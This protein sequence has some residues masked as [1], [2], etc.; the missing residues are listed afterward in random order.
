MGRSGPFHVGKM[1]RMI[2]TMRPKNTTTATPRAFLARR[3]GLSVAF[4]GLAAGCWLSNTA[5]AQE[6]GHPT[7]APENAVTS[8]AAPGAPVTAPGAPGQPVPGHGAGSPTTETQNTAAPTT[9]AP[10][11]GAPSTAVTPDSPQNRG[12]L[13]HAGAPFEHQEGGT[14][15][16][17]HGKAEHGEE[18][19]EFETHLPSI[20]YGPLKAIWHG[21][22][23]TL[24]ADGAVT[25]EGQ[26]VSGA[27][28]AGKQVD[29]THHEGHGAHKEELKLHPTIG[30]VGDAAPSPG[31]ERGHITVDG[32][33]IEL[34]NPKVAFALQSAFPEQL[35]MS[36]VTAILLAVVLFALTRNMKRVPDRKQG[37]LEMGYSALDAFVGGLIGPGYQ[38]YLPLIG[39]LFLYIFF[40]N[41]GIMIPGWGSATGNINITAGLALVVFLYVQ[42][43]GIRANGFVGYL[44]HFVGEP[45]W[46]APLNFPLH[47]IG[48]FAKLLSLSLRLFGNIFGEDTVIVILIGLV[49]MFKIAWLPL[50]APM[51]LLSMF[52]GF[53]Q[54]LV[55]CILT[56]IYIAMMTVHDDHG[57]H[58]GNDHDNDHGHSHDGADHGHA[59]AH[60]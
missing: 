54:A 56:C 60:A 52:A 47:I 45:V 49:G 13:P 36:L 51:Y 27:E 12:E 57:S 6:A 22:P 4:V 43:E 26:P 31:A 40:M 46:L 29:F 41:I 21:G 48:E 32:R 58:G 59:H 44:K 15:P 8:P 3:A 9:E 50:Q 30:A 11:T 39:A 35:G 34:L 38:K 19:E 1:I 5:G 14:A 53:V 7:T 23:A 42:I 17:E 18:K 2:R 24:T 16:A 33:E 25:A 55:F 37:I 10:N 28:L 20:L